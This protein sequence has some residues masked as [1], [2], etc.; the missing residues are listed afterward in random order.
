MCA[1]PL[2]TLLCT[3]L[4]LDKIPKCLTV[5][6]PFSVSVSSALTNIIRSDYSFIYVLECPG[7]LMKCYLQVNLMLISNLKKVYITSFRNPLDFTE[8]HLYFKFKKELK[9]WFLK[10]SLFSLSKVFPKHFSPLAVRN[11]Y[12]VLT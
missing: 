9:N 11:W 8:L 3:C 5:S 12:L 6:T 2:M 4:I 10:W 1:F 7:R